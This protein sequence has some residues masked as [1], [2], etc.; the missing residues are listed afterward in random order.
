MVDLL[1]KYPSK[2]MESQFKYK[3]KRTY[4]D[5]IMEYL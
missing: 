4:S 3:S 2:I 5:M 1:E